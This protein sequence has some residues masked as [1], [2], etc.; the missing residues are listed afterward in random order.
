MR[1]LHELVEEETYSDAPDDVPLFSYLSPQQ[2]LSLVKDVMIGALCQEVPMFPDTIQHNAAYL[3]II[4]GLYTLIEAEV[5]GEYGNVE[6]DFLEEGQRQARLFGSFSGFR[7]SRTSSKQDSMFDFTEERELMEYRAE[8]NHKKL[9]GERGD[10]VDEF[11]PE[12]INH[13]SFEDQM[14]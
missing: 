5:E 3:G 1:T 7:S 11:E 6:E 14:E 13:N 4:H 8:R 10:N 12:S 2:R 9:K